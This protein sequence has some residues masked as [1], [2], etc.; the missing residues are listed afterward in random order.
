MFWTAHIQGKGQGYLA[1]LSFLQKQCVIRS[2][3]LAEVRAE[4][5]FLLFGQ[6]GLNDLELLAFDSVSNLVY[7]CPAC[8]EEQGRGAWSDLRLHLV[9]KALVDPIVGKVP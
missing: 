1:F 8:Q 9:D 7:H 2:A 6:V 4:L 3:L 5:G